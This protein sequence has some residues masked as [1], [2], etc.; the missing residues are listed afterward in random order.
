MHSTTLPEG[1]GTA[2]YGVMG[3]RDGDQLK[4]AK[5]ILIGA[6]DTVLALA[7]PKPTESPG[8]SGAVRNSGSASLDEHKRLFGFSDRKGKRSVGRKSKGRRKGPLVWKKE[9]V[10]LRNSNQTW[11]PTSEEKID[12]ARVGLGFTEVVFHCDGDADHIHRA[13]LETFPVLESCGG[14]TLMRLAE[15]SHT[16]VEIEG[17]D[18]GMTVAYLKDVVNTAKLYIRP[19]QKDI[20]DAE[21]KQFS[22]SAVVSYCHAT[23]VTHTCSWDLYATVA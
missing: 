19:L 13:I 16:M 7:S 4:R 20:T 5:N 14:Y 2:G 17:P 18:S 9:C 3:D 6:V 1:G 8:P 21:M 22:D 11:K 10:C 23:A 15:N 12:L